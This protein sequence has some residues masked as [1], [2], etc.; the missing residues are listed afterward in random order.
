TLLSFDPKLMNLPLKN[1]RIDGYL[2]S[3][4]YFAQII[5]EIRQEFTFQD[6]VSAAAAKILHDVYIKYNSSMVVGVHARRGDFLEKSWQDLG[7]RI[8]QKSY[9]MKAFSL[10]KSK[11]PGR[12]IVFLVA[13]NDYKWCRENLVSDDVIL[14]QP[15]TPAVHLAVLS[16]CEHVIMSCGTF[17]WWAAWL[18]NGQV[19][20]YTNFFGNGSLQQK[21][22]VNQYYPPL[23]IGLDD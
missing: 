7:I 5:D 8:P 16:R 18:A 12:K 19:I 22:K 21:V 11:F 17:G 4:C 23:W 3:Y 9:F 13:S 6:H 1:V 14:M 2:Q 15:E 20:Y 10:M